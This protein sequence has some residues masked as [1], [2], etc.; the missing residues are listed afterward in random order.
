MVPI[1]SHNYYSDRIKRFIW[2]GAE[3]L[4]KQVE[5][6][7]AEFAAE[8]WDVNFVVEEDD[9]YIDANTGQLIHPVWLDEE[10]GEEECDDHMMMDEDQNELPKLTRSGSFCTN[11]TELSHCQ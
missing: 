3:E 10:E 2:S 6:N 8:G 1:P 11:L 4:S 9:M 7:R 5:R